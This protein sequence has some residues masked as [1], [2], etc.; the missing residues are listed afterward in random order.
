MFENTRSDSDAVVVR[1][2]FLWSCVGFLDTG[3][4]VGTGG[5]V[6]S[7]VLLCVAVERLLDVSGLQCASRIRYV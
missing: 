1:W 2:D 3:L 5:N 7:A 4:P 6:P